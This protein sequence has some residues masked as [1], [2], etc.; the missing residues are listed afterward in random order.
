MRSTVAPFT[1]DAD[2]LRSRC[3]TFRFTPVSSCTRSLLIPATAARKAVD[4][5]LPLLPRDL[6]PGG[7][8]GAERLDPLVPPLHP[9]VELLPH[10]LPVHPPAPVDPLLLAERRVAQLVPHVVPGDSG[11]AEA[12]DVARDAARRFAS[13]RDEMVTAA[14]DA[15]RLA[16][17]FEALH[18]EYE[19]AMAHA[20]AAYHQAGHSV[21]AARGRVSVVE[22]PR[23]HGR[24]WRLLMDLRQSW[25]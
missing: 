22:E 12:L 10:R 4:D 8:R 20:R 13:V 9:V 15:V 21:D 24:R 17:T 14:D 16:T 19:T 11:A 7:R 23:I 5:L 18:R 3:T 6:A 1:S 2:P 25:G